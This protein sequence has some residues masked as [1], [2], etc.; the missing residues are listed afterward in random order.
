[1]LQNR[2]VCGTVPPRLTVNDLFGRTLRNPLRFAR[3]ARAG[4]GGTFYTHGVYTMHKK[5]LTVAIAGAL[6]APLA[7]QAVDFKIAG[8]VNRALFVTDGDAGTKAEVAN[9]GGS[10]T[11][12][13][14]G[15]GSELM[16]GN[17]VDIQLEYEE[18]GSG[19]NLRHAN[20]KYSGAFGGVTL[21]QG[22]EAG[23]GSQYSDTT[24]VF[25]IGH[26]AGTGAGF[27]LGDYFGS[28][29][30]G[31]RVGMVRYDTPA[32]GPVSAAVSVANGD[33]V[34]GLLKL[35]SEF[36]G[37][38]FGAQLG[39]LQMPG[40]TSSIGA[41]F[42]VTMASGLTLS[43]AWAR[44]NDM[45]G[46]LVAGTPAVDEVPRVM[47]RVDLNRRLGGITFDDAV[48]EQRDI[49]ADDDSTP[50]A[51]QQA[52]EKIQ[53][54]FESY[55][56]EET[57]P[58]TTIADPDGARAMCEARLQSNPI[59]AV[60]AVL[61]FQHVTDPDYFQAEIGYKFGNTGVAVSWYQSNDFEREG[62]KGTALGIGARHT[63]PK[64]A[65]EIYAAV[66]NYDVKRTR[67]ATSEDETV[68]ML[69]TRV[70]F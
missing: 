1:M 25:G 29:D 9:N 45:L 58:T 47:T 22:S 54:F 2:D 7:A 37:T 50:A 62:S 56:C 68:F 70:K 53:G 55:A 35:S 67:G 11:R 24:G 6:A 10:S 42:G 43:G 66:Q 31:G 48:G 30:S 13:R 33:R 63:L 51:R 16:D 21:G 12:V 44:G 38:S 28:L 41:S 17:K 32:L 3:R 27:S 36:G 15:G 52:R 39:T 64:A 34:S 40:S 59:P 60:P 65:A 14:V 20:V 49:I 46:E 61:D 8:H 19:V 26:G 18:K 69:G 5:A 23:D 57:P 4:P